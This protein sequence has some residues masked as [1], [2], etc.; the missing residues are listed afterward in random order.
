MALADTLEPL[1]REQHT[2]LAE[3]KLIRTR[4]QA[5]IRSDAASRGIAPFDAQGQTIEQEPAYHRRQVSLPSPTLNPIRYD[6]PDNSFQNS[7][8]PQHSAT[9]PPQPPHDQISMPYNLPHRQAI[10]RQQLLSDRPRYT[11]VDPGVAPTSSP[12]PSLA[13]SRRMESA[14]ISMQVS[15]GQ[16]GGQMTS[17]PHASPRS[18]SATLPQDAFSTITPTPSSTGTRYNTFAEMGIEGKRANDKECRIM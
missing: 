6:S 14:G 15:H 5:R 4:T 8:P 13:S 17:S 10:Q 9:L 12:S 18:G 3:I 11:L 7:R 16:F 1:S 2:S